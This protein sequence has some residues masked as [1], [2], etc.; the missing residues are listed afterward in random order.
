MAGLSIKKEEE[1]LYT[2]KRRNIK[3]AA[4]GFKKKHS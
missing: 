4:G 3:Q 2:N 1:D